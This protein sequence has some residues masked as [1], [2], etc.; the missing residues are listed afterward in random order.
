M[1][2]IAHDTWS[3]I[4]GV[5]YLGLMTNV[6]LALGC[7]PL[8][9]L[10]VTTDPAYSWPLLAVAAPLCAPAL[11]AAFATYRAHANGENSVIVTFA[12]A[13]RA[14][15][16]KALAIGLAATALVVILFVDVR[17][18]ADSA[19]SVVAVPLL[20]VLAVVVVSTAL[21]A[22]VALSEAPQALLRDIL[23]ASLY[24]SVRRW[25]LSL[26]SLAVFGVQAAL[27]T[28]MP[29]FALGLTAAP[30]LY[31]AWANSRYILRPVLDLGDVVA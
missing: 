18:L 22:L 13:W 17:M 5:F 20:L 12:K 2:R 23:K 31:V 1:G 9:V 26:I 4:I 25:Y 21:V 10:L 29:A 24:L 28:G 16:W 30:A 11:A 8:L 7:L 15:A 27:F 14:V 6:L 19:L 3:S